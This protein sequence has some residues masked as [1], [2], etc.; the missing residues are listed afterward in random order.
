MTKMQVTLPD[1]ASEFVLSKVSSGQFA[2]PSE[3]LGFLVERA[4]AESAK[5]ELDDLLEEGLNSGTPIQFSA[6]WWRERKAALLATLP[7][8]SPE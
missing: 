1:S 6:E 7:P 8:E 5:Q 3:Y 4:R 2:T